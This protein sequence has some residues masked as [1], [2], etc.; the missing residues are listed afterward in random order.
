[1]DNSKIY[2]N[3]IPSSYDEGTLEQLF[4]AYGK[5]IDI[6][7]PI[8]KKSNLPKAYAFITFANAN[9][10]NRALEKNNEELDGKTL[11]V[12]IAEERPVSNKPNKDKRKKRNDKQ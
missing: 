6:Q 7:Y 12:E 4:S 1:M 8:D 11:I 3:H 10:A 5:I 2:V 9:S